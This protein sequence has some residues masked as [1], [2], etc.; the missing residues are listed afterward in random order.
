MKCLACF[1]ETEELCTACAKGFFI[2]DTICY[3]IC[4]D[5]FFGDL[6]LSK[7]V[8]CDAS[9]IKCNGPGSSSCTSC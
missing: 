5:G 6:T 7:C 3:T 1:G 8:L 9:C 2:K 4:P